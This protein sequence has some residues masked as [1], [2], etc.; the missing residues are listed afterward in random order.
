MHRTLVTRLATVVGLIAAMLGTSVTTATAAPGDRITPV[1]IVNSAT[2]GHLIPNDYGNN[3]EDG[4][5][6]WAWN[7]PTYGSDQWT[8]EESSSGHYL[9]RNNSTRKCL[10]PGG[11]YYAKTYVTQGNCADS[12]EYQWDLERAPF[13]NLYK[14][15]NRSTHQAMTPYYNAPNQVVVLDNDSNDAKNLWSLTGL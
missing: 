1:T 3:R 5:Y 9:I 8:L 14:I 4:I 7:G 13:S 11:T 15:V 6:T 10:K 2:S 12:F